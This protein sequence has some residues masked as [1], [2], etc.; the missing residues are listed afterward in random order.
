MSLAWL[1][2]R[3]LLMVYTVII[4]CVLVFAI[5]QALPADAASTAPALLHV[6]INKRI[7]LR[8]GVTVA[9]IIEGGHQ[10]AIRP[11]L[12]IFRTLSGSH[13]KSA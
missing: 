12:S 3:L 10:A 6:T 7:K 5:T 2:R 9:L 4:V 8:S 1:V 11:H 13:A